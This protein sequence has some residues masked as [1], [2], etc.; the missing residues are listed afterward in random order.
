[1]VDTKLICG[2]WGG[3]HV[4]V[5]MF[6]WEG[7]VCMCQCVCVCEWDK[8]VEAE[9]D[10]DRTWGWQERRS[11]MEFIHA[12]YLEDTTGQPQRRQQSEHHSPR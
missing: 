12:S 7:G 11:E 6:V 2:G 9:P 3:M 10:T 5:W 1:M 4:P 8:A